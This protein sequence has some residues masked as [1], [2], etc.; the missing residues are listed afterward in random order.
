MHFANSSLPEAFTTCEDFLCSA[1][2]CG[3]GNE[4]ILIVPTRAW[5]KKIE[6]ELVE[7]LKPRAI[8]N[9][10][11]FTLSDFAASLVSR[12][13]PNQKVI[14]DAESA[15]FLEQAI[16]DLQDDSLLSYFERPH[17][18]SE[19]RERRKL[20]VTRGTFEL[21]LNTI[22]QLK[23]NG[24]Y[25]EPLRLDIIDALKKGGETTE[26]RRARDIQAIYARYDDRLGS[27]FTDTYGQF[28]LLN[29][30]FET[31]LADH[32][33][34]VALSLETD[35]RSCYPEARHLFVHGFDT[36]DR[37]GIDLLRYISRIGG[38]H[39]SIDLDFD[40]TNNALF[41][42]LERLASDLELSGFAPYSK[43][44]ATVDQFFLEFPSDRELATGGALPDILLDH[45]EYSV[46]V[47]SKL[48]SQQQANRLPVQDH[49][50]VLQ[51]NSPEEEI[52][53]VAKT[54]KLLLQRDP[55][56]YDDLSRIGVATTV[57]L[58]YSAVL[59]EVFQRH[60]IPANIFDRH[61]LDTSQLLQS[62]LA[63]LEIAHSGVKR[64][65]LVKVLSSPFFKCQ[66]KIGE[67]ID[68]T[69]LLTVIASYHLVGDEDSWLSQL[70]TTLKNL[71]AQLDALKEMPDEFEE[72]E[73]NRSRESILKAKRDLA[74]V[75]EIVRPFRNSLK[76]FEFKKALKDL[77][78]ILDFGRQLLSSSDVTLEANTLELDTRAYRALIRLIEDLEVTFSLLGVQDI[79]LSLDF[80]IERLRVASI[81]TR[82][83]PL[84][85]EGAVHITSLEQMQGFAFDH[86]F[87]IGL[88]DGI[89]PSRYE[90]QVFL[91]QSQQ[92][93]EE[94][95]LK[96]E[97]LLFYRTITSFRS[98][99]YLC[100]HDRSVSG[101]ETS[102][103]PFVLALQEILQTGKASVGNVISSYRDYY[104]Y[105]GPKLAAVSQDK[106]Q[107]YFIPSSTLLI[108][109][110]QEII[111]YAIQAQLARQASL[112]T[113]YR[114]GLFVD[115]LTS[116]ETSFLEGYKERVWSISQ[117]EQYATCP[118]SFFSK[119]VLSLN[120][121]DD[122][123]E[124]RSAIEQGTLLHDVLREFFTERRERKELPIQDV[125]DEQYSEVLLEA[126]A[127]AERH[128]LQTQEEHPFWRLDT[129]WL[130][131]TGKRKGVLE[132][133]LER[134]RELKL[135]SP[136]PRFFEVSFGGQ[137]GSKRGSDPELHKE[138]PFE[139]EGIKF[140][141]K[142]DRIDVSDDHF[143]I[144]DYKSNSGVKKKKDLD[145]GTSLQLPLYLKVAE[146]LLQH[147][148]G[149]SM[150]GVAGLYNVV[151]SK[152]GKR[153][154][155]IAL[156]EF[157][158]R[159]FE[160]YASHSTGIL[161]S[162]EEMR[163]VIDRS[164]TLA[165]GYVAGI[166]E[167]KFPLIAKDLAPNTCSR[168]NYR[169]AC[170]VKE[171]EDLDI[172]ISP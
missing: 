71:Q 20:P 132:K 139:V 29:N 40:S 159:A 99:L 77:F 83:N 81:W 46:H 60:N 105:L 6:R 73:V 158:G 67:M 96:E 122:S 92:R 145:R 41:G 119:F 98:S 23:R 68:T 51:G 157:V 74:G 13:Y 91:M 137:T 26:I 72:R 44:K 18:Y 161:E 170:R 123:E 167:G 56:L 43:V 7:K 1:I 80:Y 22:R 53:N 59:R 115:T 116:K 136:R 30:R 64:R 48:F 84:V 82:F 125:T 61:R 171:A 19:E 107:E 113:E 130:L 169:L 172:L 138:E 148:F 146:D 149:S 110:S 76:P 10:Q 104:K 65:E 155:G 12:L 163:E 141:G 111:P 33:S 156:K 152:K 150:K 75:L 55:S 95:Q 54:I 87:V 36:I 102:I 25:P 3:Q 69:N 153:E 89:F 131:G 97:R 17:N 109:R 112:P 140:R 58:Q 151:R 126:R 47:R 135:F 66:N 45:N 94:R 31:A 164:I 144:I 79:P 129:E 100:W 52:E 11:V 34:S 90:P 5:V 117:L 108:N 127:L 62:I 39:V 118:F 38:L 63:L 4:V 101:K 28:A 166:S 168:C 121:Q 14:S 27:M 143:T 114:G 86:L 16:W 124:G 8:G 50:F 162:E 42:E 57:E 32:D 147:H 93:G 2:A 21:I 160:R 15:V 9:L 120:H 134:E 154:L 70:D 142:I 128:L 35:F 85:R 78:V 133:V 88:V 49:V 106:A 103:S 37:P 165:K 24:I